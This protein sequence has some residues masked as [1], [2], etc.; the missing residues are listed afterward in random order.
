MNVGAITHDDGQPNRASAAGRL[1]VWL[2]ER[3]GQEVTTKQ[4]EGE[5]ADELNMCSAIQRI[6]EIKAQ[7]DPRIEW[8]EKRCAFID[9]KNRH[10]YRHV[11]T[12]GAVPVSAQKRHMQIITGLTGRNDQPVR[13]LG[14]A[15]RFG[16]AAAEP[17]PRLEA[18]LQSGKRE[19]Q[20]YLLDP[21]PNW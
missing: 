16:G 3:T 18:P 15:T 6:Q 14:R 17:A 7:L 10:F 8:I 20:Q 13:S 9:G 11:H 12:N 19:Q 21:R 4:L 1:Y 2:R 5:I